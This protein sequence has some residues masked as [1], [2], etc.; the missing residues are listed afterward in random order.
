MVPGCASNAYTLDASPRYSLARHLAAR[1]R[2]AWIVESRGV[3]FSRPWARRRD[4]TDA[5][6]GAPRQHAPAWGDF[7]FD[8]YAR[9][10]L[11][12]AAAYVS[13]VTGSEALDAVGHSMGGMLLA[14][15]AASGPEITRD[16][17]EKN[18]A[19]G[20]EEEEDEVPAET[21]AEA[22]EREEAPDAAV[23]SAAASEG[24]VV[25]PS[26]PLPSAPWRLARTA[27]VAS[28]L[29]C[30]DRSEGDGRGH[31]SAYAKLAGLAGVVPAYLYGGDRTNVQLPLGPLSV[32][33]AA[34]I[35]AVKGAPAKEER[36]TRSAAEEKHTAAAGNTNQSE[37]KSNQSSDE[38]DE[39]KNEK[40]SS[41]SSPSEPSK[42]SSSSSSDADRFWETSAV[43]LSTCYPGATD[44]EVVRALLYKGFGNVPLRLVLQMATL[45]APG[46]MATR[47][48]AARRRELAV[49]E[50]ARRRA[51]WLTFRG[52]GDDD[53]GD[54]DGKTRAEPSGVA[55]VADVVDS[56][57]AN[58]TSND[59]SASS[60]DGSFSSDRGRRSALYLERVA[61]A[62]PR[63]KLFAA[64][65][66]PI[67]PPEHVRATAE[68]VGAEFQ[69][70][71]D[72]P[73][74]RKHRREEEEE[75]SANEPEDRDAALREM[76][77][78]GGEHYSHY[79]LLV[80]RNA[81]AKV[82]PA[83]SAFLEGEEE[84]AAEDAEEGEASE[85][86]AM[87]RL[88]VGTLRTLFA[89]EP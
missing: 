89:W 44:P 63:M 62:G 34:A 35:E 48:E 70:F 11:P 86:S 41:P 8:T 67:F 49:E 42:P 69:L 58:R 74:S 68:A 38:E 27:M 59:G 76:L 53:D 18:K 66:D 17:E 36:T 19:R 61:A 64:D 75:V 7:D 28:C 54:G 37:K 10:D 73:R 22:V 13:A 57:M 15:M 12:A 5:E 51:R 65:C 77:A 82:F 60:D 33:Q 71:G 87:R 43:S 40:P 55:T 6:T 81:P 88:L 31:T 2:D 46:G 14:A 45:F 3:G 25:S 20:E 80:G 78:D 84:D 30:S 56:T 32:G 1:G 47:E 24:G 16:G 52:W 85:P 50:A 83:I 39:E 4:W 26:A 29:E 21:Q 79:D 9:E 72:G 23:R